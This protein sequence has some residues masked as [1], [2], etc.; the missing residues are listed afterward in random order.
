MPLI[1]K[2]GNKAL[3]W[4]F[5][6]LVGADITGADITDP[7]AGMC[8]ARTDVLREA[9]LE[10]RNFD[11]EVDILAMANGARVAEVPIQ[12]RQRIGKKKLKPRH[13]ISIASKMISLAYRLNPTPPYPRRRPPHRPRRRP[14]RMGSLPLFRW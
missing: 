6:L 12:Y 1:Y 5:R 11:I 7:L 10:A 14:G 13:G 8:A 3:V 9:T 4:L 2:L